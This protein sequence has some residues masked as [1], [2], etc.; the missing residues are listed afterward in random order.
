MT[1]YMSGDLAK[2]HLETLSTTHDSGRAD[3]APGLDSVESLVQAWW[4]DWVYEDVDIKNH[5]NIVEHGEVDGQQDKYDDGHGKFKKRLKF[6]HLV[7]FR[8]IP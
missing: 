4:E 5:E 3:I 6:D 8:P 2:Q 7:K 1:K